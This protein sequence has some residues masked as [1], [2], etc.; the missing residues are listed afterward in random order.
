LPVVVGL[1]RALDEKNRSCIVIP[2]AV[3]KERINAVGR[4]VAT[5]VFLKRN[6]II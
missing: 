2:V 5:M 1:K 4:V 6:L 3:N